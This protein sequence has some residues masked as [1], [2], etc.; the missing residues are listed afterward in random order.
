MQHLL[1]SG[2][3][4]CVCL[5][6]QADAEL[7]AHLQ[8]LHTSFSTARYRVAILRGTQQHHEQQRKRQ[9]LDPDVFCKHGRH[10][11]LAFVRRGS[12]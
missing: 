8:G 1:D 9:H 12:P 7:R 11:T 3:L 2:V 5:V 6:H 10:E 4:L